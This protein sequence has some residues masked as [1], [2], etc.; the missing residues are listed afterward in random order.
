MHLWVEFDKTFVLFFPKC[1]RLYYTASAQ[2]RD[3]W[4]PL[5]SNAAYLPYR[6][7]RYNKYEWKPNSNLDDNC[8]LKKFQNE[9][10]R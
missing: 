7:V 4:L 10:K 3:N 9:F 5:P 2:P 6:I 1:N 8:N